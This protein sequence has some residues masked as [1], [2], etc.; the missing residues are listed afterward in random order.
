MRKETK[1]IRIEPMNLGRRVTGADVVRMRKTIALLREGL[2]QIM[3]ADAARTHRSPVT[4]IAASL[5]YATADTA[6]EY[7][8]YRDLTP[9]K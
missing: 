7:N 1:G 4:E 9:K 6:V 3:V 2:D 5:S 8:C